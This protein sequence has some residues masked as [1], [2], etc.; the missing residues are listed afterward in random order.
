LASALAGPAVVNAG[1]DKPA[2]L[3][4]TGAIDIAIGLPF[5]NSLIFNELIDLYHYCF[6]H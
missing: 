5:R 2:Q 6:S 3:N 1:W 4:I